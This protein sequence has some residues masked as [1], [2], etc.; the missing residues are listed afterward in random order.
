[1]KELLKRLEKAERE[2]NRLEK[3][4][5]VDF[6]NEELEKEFDKAYELQF[7]LFNELANEIS[8]TTNAKIDVATAR[9]L[10]NDK[11]QQLAMIFERV[12]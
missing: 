11:R 10:I 5:E 4:Y 12:A 2:T 9:Q 1:M 7:K 6:E 3:L 8:K